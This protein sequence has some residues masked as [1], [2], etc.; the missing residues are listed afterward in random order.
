V[1]TLTQLIRLIY[2][3]NACLVVF[4]QENLFVVVSSGT[5]SGSTGWSGHW[6][7]KQLLLYRVTHCLQDVVNP[8]ADMTRNTVQKSV[9]VLSKLVRSAYYNKFS[10]SHLGRARRSH[11]YA[12]KSPL[13]TMGHPKF[14]LKTAHFL[15]RSLPLL[16]HPSS[17]DPTHHPK[18]HLDPISRFATVHFPNSH[19]Q[20][21][22]ERPTNG[23]GYRSTP[24]V[25][26]LATLINSDMLD[27]ND[28]DNEEYFL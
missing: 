5:G 12:I 26:M 3:N 28:D 15:Q 10:Q 11:N 27:F 6:A 24:L 20:R 1:Q 22:T 23:M 14:T 4:L 17:T 2:I 9:C 7:V 8:S 25:L 18:R 13:V 16:K 21:P 19:T